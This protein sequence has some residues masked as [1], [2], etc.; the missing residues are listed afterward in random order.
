MRLVKLFCL[1]SMMALVA[2]CGL[3]KKDMALADFA[4]I[5][6]EVLTTDMKPETI[7]EV[8]K[9]F[10]YTFEQY[11][12]MAEK[13]KNDPKLQEQM[14]EIRLNEQKQGF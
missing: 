14:G 2:S 11:N 12:T 1:V 3:C 10:G 4:K 8:A 13:V 6:R 9:K 7:G 5:E